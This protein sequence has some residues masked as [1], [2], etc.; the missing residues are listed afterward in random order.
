MSGINKRKSPIGK[1]ATRSVKIEQPQRDP[2][3]IKIE[4][5]RRKKKLAKKYKQYNR[6]RIV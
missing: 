3:K 1:T 5:E 6:K 2:D 4:K